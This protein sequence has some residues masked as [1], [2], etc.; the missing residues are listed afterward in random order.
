MKVFSDPCGEIHE[1]AECVSVSGDELPLTGIDVGQRPEAV[2]L[3]LKEELIRIEWFSAT[4][5]QYGT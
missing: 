2:D 1:A 4:G 5:K 3:Q